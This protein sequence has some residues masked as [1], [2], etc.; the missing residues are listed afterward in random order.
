MLLINSEIG[1][2]FY[3]S[4]DFEIEQLEITFFLENFNFVVKIKEKS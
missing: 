2:K 1:K 4:I 3:F